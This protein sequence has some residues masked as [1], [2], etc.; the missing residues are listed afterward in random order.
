MKGILA[1]L[2]LFVL[3]LIIHS[4]WWRIRLPEKRGQALMLVFIVTPLLF[5]PLVGWIRFSWAE[6]TAVA[7]L[8]FSSAAAY[9]ISYAGVEETSPSL[10]MIRALEHSGERGCSL[11]D[12]KILIT[13]ENFFFP[14]L[15]ALV[16]SGV[17]VSDANGWRL[18]PRGR[19]MA[20]LSLLVS[21]IFRIQDNAGF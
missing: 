7:M 6:L 11:D 17:L 20:R 18:T 10:A 2:A 21:K 14:R 9:L 12:F 5:L 4:A 13:D 1:G 16:R 19:R 3:A 8:Y 15:E